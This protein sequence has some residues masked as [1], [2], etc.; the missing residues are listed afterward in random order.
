MATMI[1]LYIAW[2]PR[3]WKLSDNLNHTIRFACGKHAPLLE[4][5][6]QTGRYQRYPL[7]QRGDALVQ[8][9]LFVGEQP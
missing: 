6:R 5:Q 8:A 7:G 1:R 4:N 9:P 3:Y 2:S